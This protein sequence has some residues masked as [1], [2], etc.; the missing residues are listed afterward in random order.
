[1]TALRFVKSVGKVDTVSARQ[2]LEAAANEGDKMLFNAVYKFFEERNIRLRK[3]A[4]FPHGE[5][6]K[7]YEALYRKWF[8]SYE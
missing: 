4:E 5:D 1:M 8:G 6:C 7:Q 2:F 3:T